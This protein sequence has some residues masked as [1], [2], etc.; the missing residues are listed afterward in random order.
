MKIFL[1]FNLYLQ[2]CDA[3]VLAPRLFCNPGIILLKLFQNGDFIQ[4]KAKSCQQV[5]NDQMFQN[6]IWK[7]KGKYQNRLCKNF[8]EKENLFFT[9]RVQQNFVDLHHQIIIK[10]RQIFLEASV[11]CSDLINLIKWQGEA[12][13]TFES[14][15]AEENQTKFWKR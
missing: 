15:R 12:I 13:F 4:L 6:I 10:D 7:E 9:S 1:L 5:G 3:F 11:W 2:F 8:S 14:E